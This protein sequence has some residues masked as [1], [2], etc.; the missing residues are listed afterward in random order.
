MVTGWHQDRIVGFKVDDRKHTWVSDNTHL[1]AAR[2]IFENFI[3]SVWE[4][5][6]LRNR[7]SIFT[8]LYEFPYFKMH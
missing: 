4:Q 5:L 8:A 7:F 6:I 3:Y 2:I 1:D